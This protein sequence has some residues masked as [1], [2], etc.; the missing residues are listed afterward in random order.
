MKKLVETNLSLVGEKDFRSV[1]TEDVKRGLLDYAYGKNGSSPDVEG[2][3]VFDKFRAA[4][5]E[6][7]E[8]ITVLPKYDI[9]AYL[10]KGYKRIF[11]CAGCGSD[12]NTG[13]EKSPV[14][15]IEKALSLAKAGEPTAI[16]LYAG[17]Y[18]LLD[19]L[20]VEKAL[21]GSVEFPLIFT[22]V[23]N[24]EVCIST[25]KDID[26]S[27]FAPIEADDE[28]AARLPELAKSKVLFA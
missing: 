7:P 3:Y 6:M 25:S 18:N 16:C 19:T 10:K 15:T 24:G 9:D 20:C 14:A 8:E 26:F 12:E 22:A 4:V 1:Y 28:I 5:E 11:V 13:E 17:K 2:D 23:G 27:D 21:S